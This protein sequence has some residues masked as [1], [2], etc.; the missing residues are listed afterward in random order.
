MI[1]VSKGRE[2]PW[3]EQ[4]KEQWKEQWQEQF[5]KEQLKKEARFERK[6]VYSNLGT[7]ERLRLKSN[8]ME[9][10]GWVCCYCGRRITLQDSH[11]EHFRPQSRYAQLTLE[12]ENLYASCIRET[13]AGTPLHCG[14]AK[15]D[16]FD[17]DLCISPEDEGCETY[18]VFTLNGDV[19]PA[20]K[21]DKRADYMIRLLKLDDGSL[22]L[23]RREALGAVFTPE[24]LETATEEELERLR[25]VYGLRDGQ[26]MRD[27]FGHVFVRYIDQLLVP[28]E[29]QYPRELT[30]P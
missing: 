22:R 29:D 25:N 8:L 4:W 12:Y 11:I 26:G 19:I 14:H 5:N 30:Q 27:S 16:H 21:N 10:Q 3:L 17:E 15:K 20:D 24:F 23:Q 18:F 2:P 13:E 9:D 28:R 7:R 1:F 6:P